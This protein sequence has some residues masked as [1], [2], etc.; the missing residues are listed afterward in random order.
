[1]ALPTPS[2]PRLRSTDGT[3]STAGTI[4]ANLLRKALIRPRPAAFMNTASGAPRMFSRRLSPA[5]VRQLWAKAAVI[6]YL[7][8]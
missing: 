3:F 7:S 1:M 4:T 2:A 8:R 5:R 6:E